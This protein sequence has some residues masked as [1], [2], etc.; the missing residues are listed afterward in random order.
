MP[1][2]ISRLDPRRKAQPIESLYRW[3]ADSRLIGCRIGDPRPIVAGWRSFPMDLQS[4][5][6]KPAEAFP[7]IAALDL[8]SNSFHLCLAKANI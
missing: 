7:L 8:G 2:I 1:T 3:S 5:P 6:Q 4:M